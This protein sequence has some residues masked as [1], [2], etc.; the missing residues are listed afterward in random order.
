[1]ID[2]KVRIKCSKCS[3][4]FRERAHRIRN[5]FQMQ[6]PNCFKLLTFGS[7]SEDFNVRRA[8][9]LARSFDRAPY[10]GGMENPMA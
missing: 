9:K 3:M 5:G 7:S 4:M 8:L 2:E 1:M 10:S 6:C